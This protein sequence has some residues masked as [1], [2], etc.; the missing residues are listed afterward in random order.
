MSTQWGLALEQAACV[1]MSD[2]R[3]P[4]ADLV[5]SMSKLCM[6]LCMFFGLFEIFCNKINNL[7]D[8]YGLPLAPIEGYGSPGTGFGSEEKKNPPIGGFFY[9]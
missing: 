4:R 7:F 9:A 2:L 8:K 1:A 5:D 3:P 6:I